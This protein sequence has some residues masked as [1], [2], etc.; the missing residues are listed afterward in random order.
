LPIST[1]IC[2]AKS[3]A[4][5]SNPA[6]TFSRIPHRELKLDRCHLAHAPCAAA[7]TAAIS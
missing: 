5:P 7:M 2:R 6:A 3:G 4:A 1:A